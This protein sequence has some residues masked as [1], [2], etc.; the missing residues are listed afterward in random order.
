MMLRWF[1][2]G[3][4]IVFSGTASAAE[5][6][7]AQ[8]SIP[9]EISP[10]A[11]AYRA[12]QTATEPQSIEPLYQL[13][14][15]AKAAFLAG[16][17]EALIAEIMWGDKGSR[18]R[19]EQKMAQQVPGYS[20]LSGAE[21]LHYDVD[22]NAFLKLAEQ[23]GTETDRDFFKLHEISFRYGNWPAYIEPQTDI[24]GCI[25]Y[26]SSEYLDF[27]KNW[28]AFLKVHPQGYYATRAKQ[29]LSAFYVTHRCSCDSKEDTI[30]GL[31]NL[32]R[33][34]SDAQVKETIAVEIEKRRSSPAEA[35]PKPGWAVKGYGYNG[36]LCGG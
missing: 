31:E 29:Y 17:S 22:A 19:F 36:D 13:G 34:S 32:A 4:L 20:V 12:V 24:T 1:A 10:Y 3:V 5:N 23:H 15:Q 6:L 27:Y 30:H 2:A 16:N 35:A 14:E 28:N 8:I 11:K 9:E 18:A 26:G 7:V 33:I 21:S 25:K